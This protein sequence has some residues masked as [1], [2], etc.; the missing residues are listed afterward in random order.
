MN[1]VFL[2]R[3]IK[4][5]LEPVDFLLIVLIVL[6]AVALSWLGFVVG[7]FIIGFP[8][9]TVVVLAGSIF[10]AYK[11]IGRRFVEYE[12]CLTNGYVTVDKI[13][14]KS[15]RKRLTAFECSSCADI[16]RYAEQEARLKTQ[17]FDERV[18][19]LPGSDRSQAW[20]MNVRSTKTGKTL[21]VFQPDDDLLEAIRQFLPRQ[22]KFE[23]GLR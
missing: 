6:G 23:K 20:Y 22:L 1:D 3:L 8:M 7:F 21:L 2:E 16:G 18:F 4:K 19:A 14:Q 10:G 11:L 9:L 5:K 12:F 15:T 17:S 13:L